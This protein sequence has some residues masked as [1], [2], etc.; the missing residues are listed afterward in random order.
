MPRIPAVSEVR[1]PVLVFGS[2][3]AHGLSAARIAAE[4]ARLAVAVETTL[5]AADLGIE[6][7]HPCAI[8]VDSSTEG[9]EQA[10]L[11]FRYNPLLANVPILLAADA[12]SDLA[13]EEAYGW[14]ADDLVG[15]GDTDMLTRRFRQIASAGTVAAPRRRG[16]AVV[17]DPDRRHRVLCARVLRNAGYGVTFALDA[18]EAVREAT[19][20]G[21]ELVVSSGGLES[22][23]AGLAARARAAGATAPWVIAVPPRE[24]QRTRADLASV[25]DVAVH[26]AFGP[27]ENVLFV[28]N[29][30][31][32][33]GLTDARA[34]ARIL[35]GTSVRFRAAGADEDEIGYSYNISEGGLYVRTLAPLARSADAWLE[36]CPPRSDRRVRLEGQVM[37]TRGFGPN[38][39][40]TVPPGFGL[41]LTGGSTSDL[42]RFVRGYRAFT[43]EA[44]AR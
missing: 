16:C 31:M 5:E 41:R 40:A 15:R 13:F 4:Q 26:D 6:T 42:E 22:A 34:S 37:W 39:A 23:G 11:H 33:R 32:R 9:A 7:K 19:Q 29:E 17:A 44:L 12:V 35:Y 10:C 28:A 21:V 30:L 2:P 20:P 3:T 18:D 27:P 24:M 43:A 25:P 14:G 1:P 36:L 8:L 38:D